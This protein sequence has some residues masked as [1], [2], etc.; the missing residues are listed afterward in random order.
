MDSIGLHS[1]TKIQEKIKKLYCQLYNQEQEEEEEGEKDK[2]KLHQPIEI[3][4]KKLDLPKQENA[5]DCGVFVLFYLFYFLQS[6]EVLDY[7]NVTE[8]SKKCNFPRNSIFLRS[9]LMYWIHEIYI[10]KNREERDENYKRNKKIINSL[11]R[12]DNL[13]ESLL[14][15]LLSTC[16][17]LPMNGLIKQ[18]N[19]IEKNDDKKIEKKK[20]VNDKKEEEKEE[21]NLPSIE[22]ILDGKTL[23]NNQNKIDTPSSKRKFDNNNNKTTEENEKKKIKKDKVGYF[24][25]IKNIMIAGFSNKP[26]D[27]TSPP[28]IPD[29]ATNNIK[30]ILP[31]ELK[32][33]D[34]IID[35]KDL[36]PVTSLH[37]SKEKKKGRKRKKNENKTDNVKVNEKEDATRKKRKKGN[38]ENENNHTHKKNDTL[39]SK[40]NISEK[41]KNELNNIKTP[42]KKK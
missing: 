29:N 26:N 16:H 34:D 22:D 42:T 37:D 31:K 38:K 25:K 14:L 32:I 9:Y 10:E 39:Q 1:I 6:S 15:Q 41:T 3:K 7:N 33:L 40:I 13:S 30:N 5:R 24:E 21:E 20:N 36:P 4:Y 2:K 27:C 18:K 11:Y 8:W 28:V 23:N 12:K 35:Y 19:S 17:L